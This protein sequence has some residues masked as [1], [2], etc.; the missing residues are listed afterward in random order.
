MA[1]LRVALIAAE[2]NEYQREQTK[3]A[4]AAAQQLGIE[5]KIVNIEDNAI[6]QS[7]Q[8]LTL[9][10]APVGSRPQG[11]LFEPV[12]T[13]LA[14]PARLAASSGVGW[15][16]LNR[17][18]DYLS[19]LR[20]SF[21]KSPMF[22][23]TT[24]HTEV[25]RIQGEQIRALL[26]KG[27][28]VLLIQ[29]PSS[30]NAAAQRYSG[31]ESAKPASVE[32]R[33]VR[34]HWSEDS[35]YKA[36]N[37]WLKLSTSQQLGVKVVAAHNDAMALGAYKAFQ[38]DF[39]A[40]RLEAWHDVA[41]LGCDGLPTVGQSAVQQGILAATVVIPA[42]TG[43]AL[44]ALAKSFRNGMQPLET[45]FTTPESYPPVTSLKPRMGHSTRGRD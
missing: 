19:S 5:L 9:L 45:I 7:Q 28:T 16:V 22:C 24:S 35:G 14:Q 18:A 12:G 25:G 31:M 36:A 39:G 42:N 8:I 10:Q 21:P 1:T 6:E 44:E 11:I 37:G 40:G 17:E 20:E 2:T 34:G 3:A 15:V 32:V 4:R 26:P 30:N 27:G 29:G 23:V 33:T 43:V 41:F 38:E 13:A